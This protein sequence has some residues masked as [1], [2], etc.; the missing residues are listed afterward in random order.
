[1]LNSAESPDDESANADAEDSDPV[2][3][4]SQNGHSDQMGE[5]ED[6]ASESE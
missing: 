1:L 4:G 2:E 5:R 6:D 3:H